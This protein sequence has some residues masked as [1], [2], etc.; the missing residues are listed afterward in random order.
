MGDAT[1]AFEMEQ[2]T[3]QQLAFLDAQCAGRLAAADRLGQPHVVP[4]RYAWAGDALYIALDEKPKRVRPERL[5]RVQ[6]ILENSQVALVVDQYDDDWSRLAYVLVQG[7]AGPPSR[8]RGARMGGQPRPRSVSTV[9]V[10]GTGTATSHRDP[11]VEDRGMGYAFV[12]RSRRR[13]RWSGLNRLAQLGV[14][15]CCEERH[16][17]VLLPI[18][19]LAARLVHEIFERDAQAIGQAIDV[20]EVADDLVDVENVALREAR[21]LERL[22]VITCHGSRRACEL[23]GIGQ[24]GELP[25]GQACLAPIGGQLLNQGGIFDEPEQTCPVMH[26]SIV[27][28]IERRNNHGDHLALGSPHV[29]LPVHD[30][31]IQK[32]V[33]LERGGMLAV[34]AQDVIYPTGGRVAHLVVEVSEFP[35]G[36]IFVDHMNPGIM[37]RHVHSFMPQLAADQHYKTGSRQRRFGQQAGAGTDRR[38]GCSRHWK[39]AGARAGSFGHGRVVEAQLIAFDDRG[40]RGTEVGFGRAHEASALIHANRG[41]HDVLAVQAKRSCA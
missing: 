32:I 27:T 34:D 39:P 23:F 36:R 29:R 8:R 5:K 17:S 38:A 24:H 26:Q 2:F 3:P 13:L 18:S 20:G 15:P 35:L 21:Y 9:S 30:G 28:A 10:D 11:S 41:F 33:G 22:D 6:N 37:H 14:G 25:A 4:V 1:L 7:R 19:S 12:E 16:D 40:L 31:A